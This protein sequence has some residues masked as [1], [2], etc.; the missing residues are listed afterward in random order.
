MRRTLNISRLIFVVGFPRSGTTWFSNLLNSHSGTVYRHELFGRLY[1]SFGETLFHKLKF[2]NGLSDKD[3]ASAMRILMKAHVET[4]KPPFFRKN[5]R[6]FAGPTVQKLVWSAGKAI[7]AVAPLYTHWFTPSG[8]DNVVLVLKETRSSVNLASI[9]QG[10]RA[11]HLIV[12]VRHPYGVIA[13]HISGSEAGVMRISNANSRRGWF[14]ANARSQYVTQS[15]ITE[16][17]VQKISE[18]E[19]MAIGWRVQNEDY[20][21]IRATQSPIEIIRYDFFLADTLRNTLELLKTLGLER[22]DQVVRFLEESSHSDARPS[23][24]LR[25][26]SSDY[27]SVYR[28]EGFSPDKWRRILSPEEFDLIDRHTKPLVTRLGLDAA[29]RRNG[30][31]TETTT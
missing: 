29:A 22:D 28:G 14:N 20:L 13:S 15:R 4:E 23:S 18:V 11:S 2:D 10:V 3:Y 17:Y 27:Y 19:F 1:Q 12:L 5:F 30:V 7:P 24:L 8:G 9:I 16:D 26:A 31:G 6:K 25:D 21:D